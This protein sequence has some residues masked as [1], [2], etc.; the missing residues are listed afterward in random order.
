MWDE[1]PLEAG[2]FER[3]R[4]RDDF[5]KTWSGVAITYRAADTLLWNTSWA[6]EMTLVGQDYAKWAQESYARPGDMRTW[7]TEF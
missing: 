3:V 4:K 7:R 2:I 1:C 6:E 5:K